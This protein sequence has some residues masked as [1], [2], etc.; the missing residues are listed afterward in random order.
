MDALSWFGAAASGVGDVVKINAII[1]TDITVLSPLG[2]SGITARL[3]S[4][5]SLTCNTAAETGHNNKTPHSHV[6]VA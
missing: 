2:F 3:I 6:H 4:E 1:N 5:L